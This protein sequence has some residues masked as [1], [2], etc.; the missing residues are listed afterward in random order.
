MRALVYRGHKQIAVEEIPDAQVP[1]P[2]GALVRTTHF[3]IC[4][5]DLHGYRRPTDE[6]RIGQAMGHESIGEVV[7]VGSE[8]EHFRPGDRVLVSAIVGCG[9]CPP[10]R[11]LLSGRCEARPGR[12]GAQAEAIG[13]HAADSSMLKIPEGVSEEQAVLLTDILPTGYK[14]SSG[15]EIKPGDTVAVVGAGPVGQMALETA[16]LFGPSKVF[17][18]DQVAHRLEEAERLGAIAVDGSQVDPVEAVLDQTEG[19]GADKVVEAAGPPA[20]IR[21]AFD[22]LRQGGVL[23]QVGASTEPTLP[24]DIMQ[25]FGK[26]LTYK[27]GLVS[28]QLAWPALVPLIQEGK[29]HPERVFTHRVPMSEGPGAY[30]IFDARADGVIKVLVDPAS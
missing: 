13:V 30:E 12:D 3:A 6:E 8:V 23:S 15:A 5:S 19:R 21:I 22:V 7:E 2:E 25:L 11:R 27:I 4:G 14:G 24:M 1:G 29:L 18:I 10:C 17:A 9:K 26:D 28:P 20:T 16:F